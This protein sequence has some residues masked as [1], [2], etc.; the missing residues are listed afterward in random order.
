[1]TMRVLLVQPTI[2]GRARGNHVTVER[3]EAGLRS[4]GVDVRVVRADELAHFD[5]R[6]FAP[7]VVHAH[8]AAHAGAATVVWGRARRRRFVI[9]I[10][11][12]DINTRNEARRDANAHVL[13]QADGI[14]VAFKEQIETVR[15]MVAHATDD[16]VHPLVFPVRRSTDVFATTPLRPRNGRLIL[17]MFG[18]LR[19]V[20]GLTV[21][22]R[23]G[24]RVRDAGLP[25]ELVMIGPVVE[26]EYEREVRDLIRDEPAFRIEAERDRAT[27]PAAFAAIDVLLNTSENEGGANAIV[28]A[29]AHGRPVLARDV[30]GNRE[31]VAPAPNDV[32]RLTRF[33]APSDRLDLDA[34]GTVAWLRTILDEDD[35]ARA[36]RRRLAFDH[37]RSFHAPEDE[38]ADLLRVYETVAGIA[39]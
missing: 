22:I 9:S 32:G 3:W 16:V 34:A 29:W 23:W 39:T 11:G 19:R 2:V 18:G 10:G 37:A 36:D 25:L 27:M 17:G 4:R 20:K 33:D 13:R 30:A 28:E 24:R 6:S 15:A 26:P 12:T 21:A 35:A 38:I 8:H 7:H 14:V 5:E 1:M 31:L